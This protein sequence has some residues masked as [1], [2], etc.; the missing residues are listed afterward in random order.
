MQKT[1]LADQGK[2]LGG[3]AGKFRSGETLALKAG[4]RGS[5]IGIQDSA[6]QVRQAESR[7]SDQ[8]APP[9]LMA[10]VL[11]WRPTEEA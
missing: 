9:L 7:P 5:K 2:E 1:A 10:V 3:R 11:G 8:S 4:S 6:H